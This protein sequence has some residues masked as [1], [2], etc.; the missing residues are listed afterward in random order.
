MSV[1]GIGGQSALA[2]QQLISMRAQ[3]DDLQRQLSTGQKS[4]TYAGLG[5]DRGITVSLNAQLSAIGGYDN[6]ITNVM[7]RIN[8]MNTALGRMSDLGSQVKAAM[9]QSNNTGNSSGV[10]IAQQTAQSSLDELLGL[11]NVQAGDRY[12]FSGRATDQPPVETMDHILNGNGAL[13]GLKQLISERNQADL[14]ADGLG[15]LVINQ[16]TVN[17]VQVVE[18]AVPFGLKLSSLSSNLTNATTLGPA[19]GALSIDLSGGNPNAGDTVTLRFTLPDGTSDT[20]TLTATTKSPPG[21]NEFTIGLTPDVTATNLQDAIKAGVTKIGATSLTAASAIKASGDFFNADVNN[22]PLRVDG[23][24]FDTATGTIPGTTA[25]TVIWYTGE[26]GADPARSTA[27]ARIDQSL[28]VSYGARANEEALRNL[29]Q[30]I[31]TRAAVTV[32]STNP[33]AP[34]LNTALNQ[35]LAS[36]LSGGVGTQSI[37]DIETDLAAAQTSLNAAKTRHQQTSTTLNDFLQQIVGVSNEDVGA[38]ILTLQTR[39]QA[40]MQTTAML[41]QTSLVN[42]LK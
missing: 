16:P 12:L 11:L 22:P 29:V 14:G 36:N 8:L 32:P 26:V 39:M 13:A 5:L 2:I 37:T 34:D 27:T 6:T 30:N 23:P 20:L 18:D 7:T 4:A 42:Y 19:G 33:N 10:S 1:S 38:Q 9:V 40:S 25:N 41:F 24:P 15:R 21:P 28:T 17:S 3:F 31:A 35:R